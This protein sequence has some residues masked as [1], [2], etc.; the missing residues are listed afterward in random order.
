LLFVGSI[1]TAAVLLGSWIG[2]RGDWSN[3]IAVYATVAMWLIALAAT[4]YTVKRA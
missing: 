2:I 3:P 1:V 4:F